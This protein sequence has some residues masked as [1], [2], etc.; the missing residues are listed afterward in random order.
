MKGAPW[1][2][3]KGRQNLLSCA[4]TQIKEPKKKKRRVVITANSH[5]AILVLFRIRKQLLSKSC[6]TLQALSYSVTSGACRSLS[7]YIPSWN[8]WSICC[9]LE[10]ISIK[11]L[12]IEPCFSNHVQCFHWWLHLGFVL[13]FVLSRVL[14]KRS[15]VL[16]PK[17]VLSVCYVSCPKDNLAPKMCTSTRCN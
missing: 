17:I 3:S 7:W 14:E 15:Q 16:N 12:D 10:G 9:L 6:L 4:V 2:E 8:I 11:N 1:G 13:S 5:R